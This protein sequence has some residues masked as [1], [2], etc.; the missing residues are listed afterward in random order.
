MAEP[1]LLPAVLVGAGGA[2]GALCRHALT[3]L[4]GGE[5]FPV[6][7]IAVNV[8]GSFALGMVVLGDAGSRLAL[9]VGVGACG[10]FTTYSSFAVETVR[11]WE[12]GQR[13][14]SVANAVGT[15]L[16]ALGAVALAWLVV[17][18]WS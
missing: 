14:R 4:L 15:L 10:A 16:G 18:A 5:S 9:L 17:A 13:G 6:G 8:L 1:G 2:V 3:E 7:T 12:A 11:L